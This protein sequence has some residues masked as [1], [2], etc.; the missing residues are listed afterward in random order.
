[1]SIEN[2][3]NLQVPRG[4][5]KR[6][7]IGVQMELTINFVWNVSPVFHIEGRETV[8]LNSV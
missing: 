5:Y 6:A 1:M 4:I 3:L 7:W 8:S 2:I